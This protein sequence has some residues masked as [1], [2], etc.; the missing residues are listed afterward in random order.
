MLKEKAIFQ[1]FGEL[2]TRRFTSA[3]DRQILTTFVEVNDIAFGHDN[4]YAH[5]SWKCLLCESVEI[6]KLLDET[7]NQS[8]ET[9]GLQRQVLELLF[10]HGRID[11]Y[12]L[13]CI[14]EAMDK[15]EQNL[16]QLR[17]KERVIAGR[18]IW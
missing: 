13:H 4:R 5:S 9:I 1:G 15:V 2:S 8:H 7:M 16:E 18:E 6:P 12:K 17:K 3:V 10:D 14:D 11:D